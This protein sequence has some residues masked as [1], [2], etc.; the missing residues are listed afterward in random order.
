[1]VPIFSLCSSANSSKSGRRAMVPSSLRISQITAAGVRPA[2]WVR[3]QPA[4]VWPARISTP[5]FCARNGKIWPGC[6][7]SAGVEFL[8]AATWMVR[9]RSAAEIPVVTPSAASIETVKLVP[10]WVPLRVDIIDKSRRLQCSSVK[11]RHT[12][13]R[14]YLTMKL[15][16][17][18]VTKSVASTRS[19]SFSRSSSSTRI[20]MRPARSSA[21]ISSVVAIGI[22][23]IPSVAPYFKG[24]ALGLMPHWQAGGLFQRDQLRVRQRFHQQGRIAQRQALGV[25]QGLAK[26]AR[27]GQAGHQAQHMAR[28]AVE[29]QAL[30]AVA[31]QGQL[32]SGIRHHGFN[33]LVAAGLD[34]VGQLAVIARIETGHQER[35]VVSLA[36]QHDAVDVLQMRVDLRHR[37]DAAIDED[38]QRGEIALELI[39][40]VI[41]ERRDFAVFLRAQA[42]QDRVAGMHDERLAAGLGN[43]ADEVAH[44]VIRLDVVDA[45]AMLDGN[46]NRH[47]IA[48][49]LH[50][51]GHQRRFGHQAGTE[52]ALLHPFGR[53]TA[54]QVDLVVAPLLAQLGALGQV[55]RFAAAELQGHRMLFFIEI[56]MTRDVA[57]QQ[58]AGGDHFGIQPSM[59][60]DLTMEDA[61]VPVRPVHHRGDRYRPRP[62]FTRKTAL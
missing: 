56:Q 53:A 14:A 15:M 18:G 39:R 38:F 57:V 13:P 35:I 48:H 62:V 19:P 10:N 6:T 31:M 5:P 34:A 51:I 8:S 47:R 33:H 30:A 21:T 45:D 43:L 1:M 12:R 58:S 2:I 24:F 61:A 11:V 36:P 20:T 59:A 7:M 50:A 32:S 44:E 4:S 29:A 28:D 41:L 54:I 23:R 9:A 55:G 49:G 27:A 37:L 22:K 40:V 60:C 52:R 26:R 16:A 25:R 17:S 3:S 42:L 46:I